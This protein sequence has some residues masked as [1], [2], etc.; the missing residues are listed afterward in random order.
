M[1]PPSSVVAVRQQPLIATE[2]P[3]RGTRGGLGRTHDERAPAG[4][5]L[6]GDDD[7]ELAHDSGEHAP[8]RN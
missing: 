6:G 3:T 8:N 2:S 7:A 5:L 1:S 4:C